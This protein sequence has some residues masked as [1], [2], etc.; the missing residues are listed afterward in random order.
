MIKRESAFQKMRKKWYSKKGLTEAGGDINTAV[1]IV[2]K[3]NG[4]PPLVWGHGA[5]ITSELG[6]SSSG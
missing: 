5:I 4:N 2:G 6:S 1:I 3:G